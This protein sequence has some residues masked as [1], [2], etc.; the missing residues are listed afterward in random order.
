MKESRVGFIIVTIPRNLF[1]FISRVSTKTAAV[2]IADN[3]SSEIN[4]I[5]SSS[6]ITPNF[7][8]EFKNP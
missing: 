4:C 6:C 1:S 8:L 3:M 5:H 7:K 2:G